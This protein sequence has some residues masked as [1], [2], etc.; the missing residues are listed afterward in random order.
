[1]VFWKRMEVVC[2]RE[3]GSLVDRVTVIV[4]VRL[5]WRSERR[6]ECRVML[7]NEF[8]APLVEGGKCA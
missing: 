1:M 5:Q 6:K 2:V 3:E 4:R 8:F 7:K